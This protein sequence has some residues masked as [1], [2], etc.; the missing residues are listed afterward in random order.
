MLPPRHRQVPPGDDRAG[1]RLADLYFDINA[2]AQAA[3]SYQALYNGG[4][5]DIALLRRWI[6]SLLRD[7]Q[8]ARANPLL[9]AQLAQTPDD[10]ELLCLQGYSCMLQNQ[11]NDALVIFNRMLKDHP[12]N[13]DALHYR[14][15]AR[16]EQKTESSPS[17]STTS[18][19]SS[20]SI[21]TP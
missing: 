1:R 18:T 6:E 3:D 14:A 16:F 5:K 9:D 19:T 11:F 4:D 13:T 7:H 15:L 12:D 10:E 21:P 20:A 2:S 8:F 17:P